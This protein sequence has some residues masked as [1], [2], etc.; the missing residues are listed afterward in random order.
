MRSASS[1]QFNDCNKTKQ[2]KEFVKASLNYYVQKYNLLYN[3][4][5]IAATFLHAEFKDFHFVGNELELIE[6]KKDKA[7][8]FLKSYYK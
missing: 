3:K 8:D 2:L 5:L 4:L 6:E 1:D 7:L